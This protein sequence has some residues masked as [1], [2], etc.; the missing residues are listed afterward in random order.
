MTPTRQSVRVEVRVESDGVVTP[1]RVEVG[2]RWLHIAQVGRSWSDEAGDHWLVITAIPQ[3]TFE[4]IRRPDGRWEA[5]GGL[6][7]LA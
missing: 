7:A 6:P 1:L 5:L 2:G 4:L 3:R